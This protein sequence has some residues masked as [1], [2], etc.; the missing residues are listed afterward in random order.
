M[1]WGFDSGAKPDVLMTIVFALAMR[2]F[3]GAGARAVRV[4]VGARPSAAA[5]RP[6]LVPKYT[7]LVVLCVNG[8]VAPSYAGCVYYGSFLAIATATAL[9]ALADKTVGPLYNAMCVYTC[10]HAF[11]LFAYQ[12]EP[13]RIVRYVGI[14]LHVAK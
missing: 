12:M 14:D 8:I 4:P 9:G 13:V 3:P 5:G 11:V 1:A 7:C 2:Y 6:S 10:A